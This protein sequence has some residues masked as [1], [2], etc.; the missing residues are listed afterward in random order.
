MAV[1]NQQLN[2]LDCVEDSS[3]ANRRP[4]FCDDGPMRRKSSMLLRAKEQVDSMPDTWGVAFNLYELSYPDA[5][6]KWGTE[7]EKNQVAAFS[8]LYPM[9]EEPVIMP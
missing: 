2:L 7:V 5:D 9:E 6:K 3:P 4:L 1:E 8:E